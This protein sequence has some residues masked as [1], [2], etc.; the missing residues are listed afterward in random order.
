[1]SLQ[2]DT[3]RNECEVKRVSKKEEVYKDL[4]EKEHLLPSEEGEAEEPEPVAEEPVVEEPEAEEPAE[5]E[6]EAE[7]PEKEP[8]EE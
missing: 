8:E 4:E 3:L 6:P 2:K 5:E 7:E 1:M